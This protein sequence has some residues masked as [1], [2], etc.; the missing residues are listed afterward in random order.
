M[1]PFC[2]KAVIFDFDGTLTRPGALDFKTFK[3]TLGCPFDRPVLEFIHALPDPDQRA[4]AL[5]ALE[6]F[7]TAGAEASAPN[8]GAEDL[9]RR[10]KAMGVKLAILSRNSG[11]SIARAFDN[12]TAVGPGDFD[13]IVSRDDKVAL[14]PSADGVHW[15]AAKMGL[16]ATETMVVGDFIFDMEAGRRAGAVTVLFCPAGTEPVAAADF[17]IAALDELEALVRLGQ[18]LRPGKLPNDMLG[19]FLADMAFADSS[20]LVTPGVG[21]DTAALD[22]NR[23]EVLILSSDPITFA[24][25]QIGHYAAIVNANDIATSGAVPRWLLTTLLLPCGTTAAQVRDIMDQLKTA[26]DRWGVTLCGGHTEITDAVTRPVITGTMAGTMARADLIDKRRLQPGDQVIMTKAA[27]VE[28]TAIIAREM[29]PEL[30]RLGMAVDQIEECCGYLDQISILAEARIAADF[31]EVSALHDVTEGGVATALEEL[32]LAGGWALDID[33]AAIPVFPATARIA[34]LLDLDPL[35]LIGS[36]SLLIG[37]RP[38]GADVLVAR[39]RQAG[40]QASRIGAVVAA[41]PGIRARG[42]G[43]PAAWPRFEVDEI[44]RLFSRRPV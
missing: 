15:A 4:T 32:S 11:R 5:E 34:A 9:V 19:R 13:L 31:P 37:C 35:G 10:L 6:R 2:T 22:L 17:T 39:L 23:A 42:E 27:A 14:K 12:F 26:C 21:Q 36:G 40:I 24:T 1:K 44:A 38:Q 20:V 43:R 18:A 3:K 30:L 8:L 41:P 16:D 29:G 25:D 33:I 28:G 7:E